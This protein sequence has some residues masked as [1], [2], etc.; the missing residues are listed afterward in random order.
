[1]K[2]VEWRLMLLLLFVFVVPSSALPQA[3]NT[4][5]ETGGSCQQPPEFFVSNSSIVREVIFSSP[6]DFSHGAKDILASASGGTLTKMGDRL[7][8]QTVSADTASIKEKLHRAADRLN[9]PIVVNFVSAKIE[10]CEPAASPPTVDV[11]F[12]IFASWFPV[13]FAPTFEQRSQESSEPTQATGVAR[14]RLKFLP[15]LG[16]NH[17]T[18]TF[19]GLDFSGL[20][21]LGAFELTGRGSATSH[22]VS[23]SQVG[24]YA[25]ISGWLQD[26]EW[27]AGYSQF[28][29]PTDAGRIA[30]ARLLAQLAFTSNAQKTRGVVIRFGA[31]VAGG[32]NQGS[33]GNLTLPSSTL[34]NSSAGELKTY[35]GIS[36][37]AGRHNFKLSY[38]AELGQNQ[39]GARIDFAKHVVDLTAN[40]R[41]LPLDHR[42]V[43]I[44]TRFAAGTIQNLGNIP[45][46]ERF[47]GGNFEQ[48]FITG[49]AWTI[50]SEPYIRSFPENRLARLAPSSPFGGENFFSSNLTL[51][52]PIWHR[53]LVPD[54]IRVNPTFRSSLHAEFAT[55]Q[56]AF[57][58]YWRS[59]DGKAKE[60]ADLVSDLLSDVNQIQQQ[61][62]A[63]DGDSL[64]DEEANRLD[65][66]EVDASLANLFLSPAAKDSNVTKRFDAIK[67]ALAKDGDGSIDHF[68]SCLAGLKLRLPPQFANEMTARLT[69]IQEK[70]RN[71]LAKIDTKAADAKADADLKFVR[72]TVNAIVD[73]VNFASIAPVLVFDSA[74]IGPQALTDAGGVRYGVGGGIRFSILDSIRFT[75][76]YAVNPN[77]K[78]W[79]GRGAAFFKLEITSFIR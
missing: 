39:P 72:K 2:C 21:P 63:V 53:A 51:A 27:R 13:R 58:N 1:M 18:R 77:P 36:F 60:A 44:E 52:F 54:E 49:N 68:C 64:T 41:F 59:K 14:T 26:A 65:D 6:F 19:G 62:K 17:T 7:S 50:L 10:N 45:F 55:A 3:G 56:T 57:S 20:F 22:S 75:A 46:A 12:T 31:A 47:F 67:A 11:R 48:N 71:A 76:G 43:N 70:A 30:S 29:M 69:G 32:Y 24:H 78:A 23:V 37:S 73:E 28:E 15:T 9:L 42:A 74:H 66:C 4:S 34:L 35:A 40:F 79:E 16:Y 8:L 61:F 33:V 38:A 25:P 5:I